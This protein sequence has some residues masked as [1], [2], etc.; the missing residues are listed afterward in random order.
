MFASAKA[1]HTNGTNEKKTFFKDKLKFLKENR[2]NLLK[3]SSTNN[4]KHH[5]NQE[6]KLT[7]PLRAY[8]SP[9]TRK[10]ENAKISI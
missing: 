9:Q 6:T 4:E 1:R 2:Q 7:L 3:M 5:Q 10:L 8:F